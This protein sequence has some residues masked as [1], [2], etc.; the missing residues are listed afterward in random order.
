M[1]RA[2]SVARFIE[3]KSRGEKFALALLAERNYADSYRYFLVLDKAPL[4]NL[5]QEIPS[6]LFVI[7]E[8]WGKVDCNPI[9]NPLWEI[10]AFGWAEIDRQWELEGVKVFKLVHSAR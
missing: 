9:G 4:V 3:E 2:R 10:A 1:E 5:H 8:P 6:Q 7:C